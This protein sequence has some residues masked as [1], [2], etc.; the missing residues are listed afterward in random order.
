MLLLESAVNAQDKRALRR[1]CHEIDL[2]RGST[3][4]APR[5]RASSSRHLSMSTS[6]NPLGRLETGTTARLVY[7]SD[8]TSAALG[9]RLL[10]VDEDL[11]QEILHTGVTIKGGDT[12]PA[13]LCTQ[14]RT[15][16]LQELPFSSNSLVLVP[17]VRCPRRGTQLTLV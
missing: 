3:H 10:E 15:F 1:A 12:E 4:K 16:A 14:S 5:R 8:F 13:V 17:P 6:G 9:V 11:L 2:R 7:A